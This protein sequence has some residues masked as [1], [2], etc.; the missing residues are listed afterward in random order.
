[1]N[2]F[3]LVAALL[4]AQT[5]HAAE[6]FTPMSD[7]DIAR[8]IVITATLAI[9]HDQTQQIR[10]IRE[11]AIPG[12]PQISEGNPIIRRHFSEAGIRNY[13]VLTAVGSAVLTKAM[14]KEWRAATQYGIIAL[15][16]AVIIKNKRAGLTFKF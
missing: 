13:F 14:P 5:T 11:T 12:S 6:W 3:I 15:Q 8:Q 10:V 2:K 16:V 9:D 7:A 1:M 4:T